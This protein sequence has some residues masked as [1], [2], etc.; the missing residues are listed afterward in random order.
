MTFLK[1]V[2]GYT[3]LTG[4]N[5]GSLRVKGNGE[6]W[7]IRSTGGNVTIGTTLKNGFILKE[8]LRL[9]YLY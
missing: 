7:G 3:G 5:D 6:I 1:L 9:S 4:E 8:S 2:A